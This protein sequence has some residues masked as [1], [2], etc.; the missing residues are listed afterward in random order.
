ML[1]FRRRLGDGGEARTWIVAVDRMDKSFRKDGVV[2]R[3][4]IRKRLPISDTWRTSRARKIE[5]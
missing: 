3:S 2:E 1:S 4:G 5:D